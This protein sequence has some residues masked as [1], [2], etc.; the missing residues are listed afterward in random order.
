MQQR[1]ASWHGATRP[2]LGQSVT[3]FVRWLGEPFASTVEEY[4]LLVFEHETERIAVACA[5]ER[6]VAVHWQYRVAPL[7]TPP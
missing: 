2:R 6:V 4:V 5:G 3:P 7:P 1:D